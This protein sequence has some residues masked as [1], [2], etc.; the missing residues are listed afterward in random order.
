MVDAVS[1]E[2]RTGRDGFVSELKVRIRDR[3]SGTGALAL[4]AKD[5]PPAL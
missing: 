2:G 3:A 5:G 4:L 1:G